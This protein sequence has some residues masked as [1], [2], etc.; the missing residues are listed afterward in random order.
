MRRSIT[1]AVWAL[2]L[3]AVMAAAPAPSLAREMLLAEPA[4]QVGFLP[5]G[6]RLSNACHEQT[7]ILLRP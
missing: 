4:H 7:A 6:H 2:A 5:I 1:G 3:L